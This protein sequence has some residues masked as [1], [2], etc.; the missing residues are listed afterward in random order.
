MYRRILVP[1]DCLPLSEAILPHVQ[2]LAKAMGSEII[3]LY[4]QPSPAPEFSSPSRP[5]AKGIVHDQKRKA[6][7]YLKALCT[8]LEK[9]STRV[10]YL[11]R[12]GAVPETIIEVA[13]LMQ[14]EMIAMSTQGPSGAQLLL[15]GSV[16]YQ[17]VRHSPLPVM[18]IRSRV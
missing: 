13:G 6:A 5:F 10:T 9:E 3:L 11:I 1:L 12:D 17:V 14:T 4:V 15:L 7:R 16:T 2:V 18:V 8:K